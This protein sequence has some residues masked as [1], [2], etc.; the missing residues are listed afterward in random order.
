MKVSSMADLRNRSEARSVPALALSL[1]VR[2]GGGTDVGVA[3]D[4]G[5]WDGRKTDA[6]GSLC[7]SE[8]RCDA[9]GM[10]DDRLGPDNVCELDGSC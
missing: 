4:S 2:L 8:G 7:W 10:D 9:V 6:V 3:G 1:T 5:C